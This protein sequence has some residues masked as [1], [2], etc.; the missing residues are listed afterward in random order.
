MDA[1]L[2][3]YPLTPVRLHR[4]GVTPPIKTEAIRYGV[5]IHYS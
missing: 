3:H 1:V 4:L 2:C 5:Y